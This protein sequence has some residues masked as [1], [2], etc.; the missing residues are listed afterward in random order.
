MKKTTIVLLAIPLLCGC[1]GKRDL[2]E[3][4]GASV[5]HDVFTETVNS[6]YLPMEA[7]QLRISA[8]LK[9]HKPGAHSSPDAHGAPEYALLI[10]IDGQSLYVRGDSRPEN[11]EPVKLTDPEAGDGIRY[12]FGAALRLAPGT[13]EI[14]AILPE[15]GVAIQ[16]IFTLEEGR[17]NDLIIEP[18]YATQGIPRPGGQ[19][20]VSFKGGV[21]SL[22]LLLNS[23]ELPEGKPG[24]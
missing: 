16:R 3:K 4:Y 24:E 10:N 22:R 5:R 20:A 8:S 14:A 21:R 19:S 17:I 12:R 11:S 13:H 18:L 1:A 23:G 6:G 2:I 7:T 9:T 15:D